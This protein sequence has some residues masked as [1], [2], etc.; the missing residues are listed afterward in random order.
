MYSWEFIIA[1]IGHNQKQVSGPNPGL[2]W[3]QVMSDS[4]ISTWETQLYPQAQ[5]YSLES[6]SLTLNTEPSPLSAGNFELAS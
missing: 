6:D 4:F 1:I 2:C 3:C 5:H